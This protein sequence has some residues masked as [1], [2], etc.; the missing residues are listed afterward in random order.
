MDNLIALAVDPAAWLAFATL[1]VMEIVLGVD[2]LVFV[3]ILS[4]KLPYPQNG[5]ARRIGIGLSL[6]FRILLLAAAGFIVK[7][8]Q[9]VFAVLEYN[10]SWRDLILIAGG[11]FL[12]W[13]ATT[14]IHESMD[15]ADKTSDHVKKP[16]GFRSV[17]AQIVLLDIV[18]SIDSIITAVGMTE[19]VPIMI[20][21]VIVAVVAM[22]VAADSL[23]QFIHKNPTIV[24]LAL[25]F[26][27]LIGTTLIADG[28]GF[29]FPKGYIYVAMAF[30]GAVEGLNMLARSRRQAAAAL[31]HPPAALAPPPPSSSQRTETAP[32]PPKKRSARKRGPEGRRR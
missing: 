21:S 30:S 4:N 6:I 3:A 17:V 8:T 2:N 26:L 32:P 24:M 20:V 13:K 12:V 5:L 7:L 28:F 19:H 9:P 1:V 31:V 29:H 10:F 27:L 16:S 23:A 22:L 14:E 25:G 11:V 18:F 15:I